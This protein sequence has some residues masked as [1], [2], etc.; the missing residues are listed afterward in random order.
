M[1]MRPFVVAILLLFCGIWAIHLARIQR[2]PGVLYDA[3]EGLA[4]ALATRLPI[5]GALAGLALYCVRPEWM[6]WAA[7]PISLSIE[8]RVAGLL[9]ASGAL[10]WLGS[11]IRAL[12]LNFS[13]SLSLRDE[14]TLVEAGPYRFI[15]HPMYAGFVGIFAGLA[16]ASANLFIGGMAM[17][18]LGIAMMLRTPIEEQMLEERFG[19]AW[20]DYRLRTGRFLPRWRSPSRLAFQAEDSA[21]TLREGLAEYYASD[22]H[23]RSPERL[24]PEVRDTVHRHDI[25]HVIFGCGTSNRDE[26]IL[27]RWMLL[28]SDDPVPIY[29]KGLFARGTRTLLV[30]FLAQARP[31]SLLLGLIDGF[32]AIGRSV[33]MTARWPSDEAPH[34]DR[35]LVD[36]R[37]EFGIRVL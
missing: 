6:S 25:A 34:L 36:L 16:L 11:T 27:T 26:V 24:A 12:G 31:L 1:S 21:L 19:A 28:G 2:G 18:G 29:L 22:P 14:Q 4:M 9:L 23:L 30:E 37:R 5:A 32:R 7:T 10:I 15:R 3:R 35:Q 8:W 17:I 13:M 33:E 20:C